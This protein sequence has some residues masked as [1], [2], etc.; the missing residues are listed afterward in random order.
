MTRMH[1]ILWL[2]PLAMLMSC[3]GECYDN[4]NALPLA[5]FVGPE[6]GESELRGTEV[7]GLDSPHDSVLWPGVTPAQELYLP[8]RVDADMTTYVFRDTVSG[9]R[10][11]VRFDYTR[12]PVLTSYECGVSYIYDI[13]RISNTG[14]LFDS[15]TCPSGRITNSVLSN[16]IIYQRNDEQ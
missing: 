2:V 4:R 5:T 14:A 8:F 16:L 12:T 13:K 3:A 10:D 1:H 9:L 11:T 7:Y 6:G 15:V